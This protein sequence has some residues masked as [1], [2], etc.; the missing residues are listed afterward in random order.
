MPSNNT[1]NHFLRKDFKQ[2]KCNRSNGFYQKKEQY[3]YIYIYIYIKQRGGA[4]KGL[5]GFSSWLISD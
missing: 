1:S 4:Q 5:E 3:I 2:K